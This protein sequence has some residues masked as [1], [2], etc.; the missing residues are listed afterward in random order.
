MDNRVVGWTLAI[1]MVQHPMFK[2]LT[3]SETIPQKGEEG[4]RNNVTNNGRI[5]VDSGKRLNKFP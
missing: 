5:G 1:A 2:K 3:D 4:I